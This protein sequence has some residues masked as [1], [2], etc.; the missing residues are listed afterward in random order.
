MPTSQDSA[1]DRL[2]R[3]NDEYRRLLER[4]RSFDERLE[5]LNSRHIL[6]DEEKVE[7]ITLKKHKLALKDRMAQIVR[8][9][10]HNSGSEAGN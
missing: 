2:A 3:E 7:A 5:K 9:H 8:E 10:E 1:V 6:S 4:H